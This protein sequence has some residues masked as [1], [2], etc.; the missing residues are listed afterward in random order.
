MTVND[1]PQ[2]RRAAF[3]VQ[4][5]YVRALIEKILHDIDFASARRGD[6]FGIDPGDIEFGEALPV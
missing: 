3:F 1:A 6:Q 4:G 5:I 2:Q